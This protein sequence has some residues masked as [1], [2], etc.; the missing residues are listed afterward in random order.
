VNVVVPGSRDVRAVLDESETGERRAVAACP[1]HPEYGGN[2]SD[3]R[4]RAV[5]DALVDRGVACLRF[6]Y[7]PWDEGRGE[8]ADAKSAVGW[9][10]ERYERAGLFGYSFGAAV[11]VLAGADL[12]PP[13]AAV[14]ALAP[15][16]RLGGAADSD[17]PAAVD[18]LE[19]PVQIVYG[20]RDDT[21]N[22]SPVVEQAR[23]RGER[24]DAVAADHQFVG[25]HETVGAMVAAFLADG[26]DGE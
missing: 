13:P 22:W 16:D 14:S 24:V 10:R 19:C 26:F 8:R 3:R 25:Q 4:L 7:G 21:T 12:S 2:K 1:P 11:A 17:V 20:E 5:A 6:D 23:R 9:L 15:P 18:R